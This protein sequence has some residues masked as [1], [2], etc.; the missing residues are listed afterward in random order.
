MRFYDPFQ[1]LSAIRREFDR[2]FSNYKQDGGLL[3]ANDGR[4][5]LNVT[6]N[7]DAY[8]VELLAP[9]VDPD[10]IQVNVHQNKLNISA[11]RKAYEE[12]EDRN[13]HR[14]ERT[15]GKFSRSITLN[16]AID[17]SKVE[18]NYKNGVLTIALK[19]AESAKPKQ[20]EVKVA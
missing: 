18:A 1:E 7:D 20:I 8:N 14:R 11:E 9:G 4:L 3:P 5:S 16:D 13:W 19:K 17:T 10:S 6:E 2:F 12:N 15:T